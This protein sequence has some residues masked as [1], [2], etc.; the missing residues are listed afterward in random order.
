MILI[1]N[2]SR[3]NQGMITDHLQRR[4]ISSPQWAR[5]CSQFF[6]DQSGESDDGFSVKGNC[7]KQGILCFSAAEIAGRHRCRERA[8]WHTDHKSPS[9]PR[10]RPNSQWV[11]VQLKSTHLQ[12]WNSSSLATLHYPTF[13]PWSLFWRGNTFQ[14]MRMNLFPGLNLG[15]R[16]NLLTST[17]S[18]QFQKE[19]EEVDHHWRWACRER[20]I[21]MPSFIYPSP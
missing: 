19:I 8:E 9:P 5:W 1:L 13:Q 21:S 16:R 15:S 17:M 20:L 12:L 6:W 2:S 18:S 7:N 14:M 4:L 11:G 3:N 10:S